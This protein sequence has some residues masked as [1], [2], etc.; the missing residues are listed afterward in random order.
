MIVKD[1][2]TDPLRPQ[3]QFLQLFSI[4]SYKPFL[5]EIR[6]GNALLSLQITVSAQNGL[7][8]ACF[9]FHGPCSGSHE[10][11][12]SLVVAGAFAMPFYGFS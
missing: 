9:F 3:T 12:A 8:Q 7:R 6:K 5:G 2:P 1:G 10:V 11:T 4:E